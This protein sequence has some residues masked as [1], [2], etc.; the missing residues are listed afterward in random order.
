MS[1]VKTSNKIEQLKKAMIRALYENKGNVSIACSAV[2]IGRT[3][4]YQ[5]KK[6]DKDFADAVDNMV[7][8]CIDHVESQLHKNIDQGD[9][10]AII[11][12]LKTIGKR[13]GYIERSEI[14]ANVS[15]NVVWN[16]T[17]T[18]EAKQ[19]TNNRS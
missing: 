5:W 9:T 7:D 1:K 14:E 15:G 13:R 12:Y 10:T 18:Y 2:D 3:Q 17:K 19:K 6:D 16:E 11:F 4:F 8:F